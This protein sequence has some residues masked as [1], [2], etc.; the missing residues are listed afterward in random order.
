MATENPHIRA[1][2]IEASEFPHLVQKY[3]IMGVPKTVVNESVQF[4]GA[5]PENRFLM[6][7]MKAQ[8]KKQ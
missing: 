3:R 8:K 1:D 5:V 7:V 6:E 2:V 4:E